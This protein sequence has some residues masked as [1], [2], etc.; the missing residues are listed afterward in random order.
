[1]WNRPGRQFDNCVTAL[2]YTLLTRAAGELY[3]RI[4]VG[5]PTEATQWFSD[6]PAQHQTYYLGYTMMHFGSPRTEPPEISSQAESTIAALF[7]VLF[8]L[9]HDDDE[10]RFL[11]SS[12]WAEHMK[13]CE[14]DDFPQ[15]WAVLLLDDE[16][17]EAS[18]EKILEAILDTFLHDRDYEIHAWAVQEEFLQL[19][20]SKIPV[21]EI[22]RQTEFL[23]KLYD[24]STKPLTEHFDALRP[25]VQ[26]DN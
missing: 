20:F 18:L 17:F 3:R 19:E 6:F 13:E 12:V 25:H 5:E 7:E 4:T 10:M 2:E 24:L 9:C 16:R 8:D 22:K 11:L 15:E 23:L 1:M 21:S 26:E 14:D